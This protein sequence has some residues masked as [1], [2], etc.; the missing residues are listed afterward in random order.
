MPTNLDRNREEIETLGRRIDHLKKTL[1]P[2]DQSQAKVH[3]RG[4]PKKTPE[5]QLRSSL[6]WHYAILVWLA[7]FTTSTIVSFFYPPTDFVFVARHEGKLQVWESSR[8][9]E[10]DT[11]RSWIELP[12]RDF[13][14]EATSHPSA[15]RWRDLAFLVALQSIAIVFLIRRVRRKR[16][17]LKS[18]IRAARE[19]T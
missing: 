4:P 16:E 19:R 18:L 1:L 7:L 9:F 5:D 12:P 8:D 14:L 10:A 2:D 13:E 17:E 15:S 6:G 11:G 3:R